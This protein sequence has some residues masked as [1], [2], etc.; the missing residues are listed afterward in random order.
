M[1]RIT[2]ILIYLALAVTLVLCLASCEDL[3]SNGAGSHQHEYG[4][5]GEDSA[6]CEAEGTQTRM[7]KTCNAKSTRKTQPLGHD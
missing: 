4:A 6:T 2:K 7:C 1:K 5:W 3:L